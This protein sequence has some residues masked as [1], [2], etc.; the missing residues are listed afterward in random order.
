MK[1]SLILAVL[2]LAVGVASSF[3]QGSIAFNTYLA[4]GSSGFQVT[5]GTPSN[6]TAGTAVDGTFTGEL[7]Y[8]LTQITDVKGTDVTSVTPALN[9]GWTVGSTATSG[10]NNPLGY[11]KGNNLVLPTYTSGTVYFELVAF[12][13]A[14]YNSSTVRGHSASFTATMATGQTLPDPNQ[15]NAM[16]SG[17]SVFTVPEPSTLALAGLGLAAFAAY[18]RKQA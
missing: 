7:L 15:I 6:G 5:Y 16:G 1:K 12:N 8:S 17:F 4:N 14:D 2:G 13:G 11:F 3:G 18:R 9:A 10:V